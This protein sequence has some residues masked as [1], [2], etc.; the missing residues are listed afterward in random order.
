LFWIT[1]SEENYTLD[2]HSS[3]V[4]SLVFSPD[5]G[6]LASGDRDGTIKLWDL[7][8]KVDIGTL[9]SRGAAVNSLAFSPDG[10]KLASGNEDGTIK[11]WDVSRRTELATVG[12]CKA[13]VLTVAFGSDGITLVS[14]SKG[15]PFMVWDIVNRRLI[16]TF[17]DNKGHDTSGLALTQDG[18]TCATVCLTE[19]TPI[20]WDLKTGR[21]VGTFEGNA[22]YYTPY[23]IAV[24]PDGESLATGTWQCDTLVWDVAKHKERLALGRQ[25][26][27]IVAVAFSPDSRLLATA[28]GATDF[29][30]PYPKAKLWDVATGREL[31]CLSGT[32]EGFS[33][34]RF[35]PDGKLLATASY[36]KK[37]RMWRFPAAGTEKAGRREGNMR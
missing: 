15:E 18:K 34:V 29:F 20:L 32:K 30:K 19:R 6:M 8:G 13:G 4:N 24:S 33:A 9:K 14:E 11:L 28:E 5:G 27:C 22:N 31:G 17:G 16:L 12:A 36:D 3:P 25:W 21:K 37:I 26:N 23:S 10:T 7:D 35:S 2:G 1:H